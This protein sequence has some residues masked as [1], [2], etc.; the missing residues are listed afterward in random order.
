MSKETQ[1]SLMQNYSLKKGIKNI[2]KQGKYTAVKETKQLQERVVF[3]TI[4]RN[5]L[6]EK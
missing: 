5:D 1:L 2:G 4:S 3:E 6:P